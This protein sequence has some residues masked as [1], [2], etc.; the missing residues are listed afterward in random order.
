M[1]S[2]GAMTAEVKCTFGCAERFSASKQ[3][4]SPWG[5]MSAPAGSELEKCWGKA[6]SEENFDD[7]KWLSFRMFLF[8][9]GQQMQ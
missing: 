5:D 6:V 7:E 2:P 9:R 4:S 8:L 1:V 3:T